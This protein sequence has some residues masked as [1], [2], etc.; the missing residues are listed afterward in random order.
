MICLFFFTC[1]IFWKGKRLPYV[2]KKFLIVVLFKV[3]FFPLRPSEFPGGICGL[4][5]NVV[6]D[7]C[8]LPLEGLATR[9]IANGQD[10]ILRLGAEPQELSIART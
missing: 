7:L 4:R 8:N 2:H 1:N 10:Y 3:S 6:S 9:G 5:Q